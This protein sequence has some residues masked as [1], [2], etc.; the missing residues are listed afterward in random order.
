MSRYAHNATDVTITIS[1]VDDLGLPVTGLDDATLPDIYYVKPK[2]TAAQI[3]LDDLA[4]ITDAHADGGVFEIGGGRYR[5][6]LPDAVFSTDGV[7]VA[8]Y[9]EDTDLRVIAEPIAVGAVGAELVQGPGVDTPLSSRLDE[10]N[11][12]NVGLLIA[13]V[14]GVTAI[15]TIDGSVDNATTTILVT[16]ASRF[17]PGDLVRPVG[18]AELLRVTA[19]VGDELTVQR[20]MYETTPAAIADGTVLLIVGRRRATLPSD[21]IDSPQEFDNTGQTTGVPINVPTLAV[22]SF[23]PGQQ[24]YLDAGTIRVGQNEGRTI[25]IVHSGLNLTGETMRFTVW[26]QTASQTKQ[27]IWQLEGADVVGGDGYTTVDLSAA[28]TANVLGSGHRWDLWQDPDDAEDAILHA[29][30]DFRVE[31]TTNAV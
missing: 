8:I 27:A 28:E 29:Q 21:S 6:D 26:R 31:L 18:S 10:I 23:N 13:G 5:L 1:V 2:V 11:E 19:V 7:T 16:N 9:G 25:T 24:S 20:G 4:A 17:S 14:T 3:T 22:V 30:G 15:D 12:A